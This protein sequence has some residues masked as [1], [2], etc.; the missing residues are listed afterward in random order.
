ME[1]EWLDESFVLIMHDE[2]IEGYGGSSGLR[3]PGLLSASLARPRHL[4]F[5]EQPTIFELAAAYGFA[6][7]KNHPFVDGNKR[8]AHASMAEFL[9]LNGYVLKEPESDAVRLMYQIA[10]DK[11]EQDALAI[12]LRENSTEIGKR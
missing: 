2:L 6:L 8:T 5:Y 4:Y 11:I 12:W 10:E 3:D 1:P 9:E 7:V